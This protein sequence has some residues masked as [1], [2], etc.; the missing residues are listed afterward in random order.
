MTTDAV[1]TTDTYAFV[2]QETT[3]QQDRLKKA[4]EELD[5]LLVL[6]RNTLAPEFDIALMDIVE[7]SV[8]RRVPN[9]DD[10]GEFYGEVGNVLVILLGQ[11]IGRMMFPVPITVKNALKAHYAADAPGEIEFELVPDSEPQS[12]EDPSQGPPGWDFAAIRTIDGIFSGAA[13][14]LQSSGG[15]ASWRIDGDQKQHSIGDDCPGGHQDLDNEDLT[16][17]AV[18]NEDGQALLREAEASVALDHD[19]DFGTHSIDDGCPGGHRD[20]APQQ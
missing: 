16:V 2:E 11:L 19:P 14:V 7:M 17:I 20:P 8:G 10:D 6:S 13:R 12:K 1:D 5:H 3:R 9:D 18:L 15:Q 4:L